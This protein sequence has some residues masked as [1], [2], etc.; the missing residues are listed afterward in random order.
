MTSEEQT[1][2]RTNTGRGVV[3]PGFFIGIIVVFTNNPAIQISGARA[4]L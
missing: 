4:A 2:Q 3:Y 1:L